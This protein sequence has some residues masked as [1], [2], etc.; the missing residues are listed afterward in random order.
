MGH[1]SPKANSSSAKKRM[2]GACI[3]LLMILSFIFLSE[4]H[5]LVK[6]KHMGAAMQHFLSHVAQMKDNG[7]QHLQ[8]LLEISNQ[9][10]KPES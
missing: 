5:L 3:S 7:L 1:G 2:G 9:F 4:I 10:C 8:E 6:A